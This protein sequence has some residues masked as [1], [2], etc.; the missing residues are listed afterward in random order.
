[1]HIL[2]LRV[3]LRSRH[4][5]SVRKI[6]DVATLLQSS[7]LLEYTSVPYQLIAT[8]IIMTLAR[9]QLKAGLRWV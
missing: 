1:M 9:R 8:G 7:E 3:K 6:S 2:Y 4:N 5:A